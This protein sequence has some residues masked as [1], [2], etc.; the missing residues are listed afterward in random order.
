VGCHESVPPDALQDTDL[1]EIR[2]VVGYRD[3]VHEQFFRGRGIGRP[4]GGGHGFA[5]PGGIGDQERVI[6]HRQPARRRH[7]VGHA[8]NRGR[9]HRVGQPTHPAERLSRRC[10]ADSAG[11]C[12]VAAGLRGC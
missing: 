1:V 4:D 11:N 9:P 2:P 3:L 5:K 6:G 10:A 8:R 7:H 12:E